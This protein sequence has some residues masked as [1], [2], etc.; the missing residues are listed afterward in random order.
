M[1]EIEEA[2]GEGLSGRVA[3]SEDKVENGVAL[4]ISVRVSRKETE[5]GDPC[6]SSFLDMPS[7]FSS[8]TP[9]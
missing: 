1:S 7:P 4:C 6:T 5:A 9:R 2:V 3:A 8:R